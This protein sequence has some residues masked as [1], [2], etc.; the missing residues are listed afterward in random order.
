MTLVKRQWQLG[1]PRRPKFRRLQRSPLENRQKSLSRLNSSWRPPLCPPRICMAFN[2]FCMYDCLTTKHRDI[3]KLTA[4][5]VA[6]N[7]KQF[8]AKIALRE[9][10]NYQFDFLRPA[11]S[12]FAYFT[13]LVEQ[14]TKI[15]IPR[16]GVKEK[17]ERAVKDKFSV[18]SFLLRSRPMYILLTR[19]L[20]RTD[21]GGCHESSRVP[22]VPR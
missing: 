22:G 3:I 8:M 10:K 15:L 5:F 13:R 12:L 19:T 17:L 1:S 21:Y 20:A 11:H 16:E 6:R 2:S 4:L 18:C 7:G 14:Y 9:A